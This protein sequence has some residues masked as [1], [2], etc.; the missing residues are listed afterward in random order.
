GNYVGLDIKDRWYVVNNREFVI[1]ASFDAYMAVSSLPNEK[2]DLE[3]NSY[4]SS[5]HDEADVVALGALELNKD[6]YFTV[7]WNDLRKGDIVGL[8]GT[9]S[10]SS[11]L[12]EKGVS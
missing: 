7:V 10:I 9:F 5:H 3:I 2:T 6:Y 11:E 4:G 8:Q 1:G 12:S